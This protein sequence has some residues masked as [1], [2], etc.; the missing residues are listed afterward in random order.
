MNREG[1]KGTPEASVS[2][3]AVCQHD[4]YPKTT[5]KSQP[6]KGNA[7]LIPTTR[8]SEGSNIAGSPLV[9][10]CPR[11]Y[12]WG[13]SSLGGLWYVSH[14]SNVDQAFCCQF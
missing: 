6:W 12:A 8:L 14:A 4:N 10:A 7:H 9:V 1:S 11:N 13:S 3:A 2:F 5:L